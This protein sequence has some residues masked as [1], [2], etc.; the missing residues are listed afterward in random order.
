MSELGAPI[1]TQ[2]GLIQLALRE[3]Q[4]AGWLLFDHRQRN[5][6]A[7]RLLGLGDVLEHRFFYWIPAEGMPAA[8]VHRH[9][10]AVLPELPGER[11]LYASSIEMRGLLER[12]L[13]RE[14]V[15]CLE[16]A[17]Y[18]HHADIAVVDASTAELIRG[19]NV[20]LRSSS[21]LANRFASPLSEFELE[22]VRETSVLLTRFG[23]LLESLSQK[24]LPTREAIEH[25]LAET[26]GAHA[27]LRMAVGVHMA[28]PRL[29]LDRT[30]DPEATSLRVDV[31]VHTS[32]GIAIPAAFIVRVQRDANQKSFDEDL[33]DVALTALSLPRVHRLLGSNIGESTHAAARKRGIQLSAPCVGWP[34]GH[35]L[36]STHACTF[37]A[38]GFVDARALV[39]GTCWSLHA[40]GSREGRYGSHCALVVLTE[41]GLDVIWESPASTAG[42]SPRE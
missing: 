28:D 33:R 30:I 7:M 24:A 1:A 31:A 38:D 27:D 29:A 42:M 22:S 18:E 13:P 19:K 35:V 2:L 9:D 21:E 20:E 4:R 40:S 15:I 3:R 12:N 5:A 17:P 39:I 14:G 16:Q 11:L 26:L 36:R 41:R 8:I 34:L 25:A 23:G 10:D 32:L 6:V 37:D